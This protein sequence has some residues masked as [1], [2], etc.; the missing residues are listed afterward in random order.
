M[1]NSQADKDF[2][3]LLLNRYRIL[4]VWS[5]KKSLI[6]HSL[7]LL[8]LPKGTVYVAVLKRLQTNTAIVT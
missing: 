2:L 6:R 3:K 1:K 7:Q 5:P 4:F 8:E